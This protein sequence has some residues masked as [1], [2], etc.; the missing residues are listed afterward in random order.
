[1]V[2]RQVTTL[3]GQAENGENQGSNG[4]GTVALSSSHMMRNHVSR[5]TATWLAAQ[6]PENGS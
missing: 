6:P 1:M 5:G 3:C 2:A 4:S